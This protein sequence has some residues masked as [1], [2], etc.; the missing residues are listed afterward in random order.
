MQN[1]LIKLL[2]KKKS[3]GQNFLTDKNIANKIIALTVIKNKYVLE[4]G[5]GLG[6]LTDEIIKKEP[7]ELIL[8]EK[9]NEIC[10]FLRDKYKNINEIKIF[11]LDVLDFNY[12]SEVKNNTNVI[13]NLPYNLSTKIILDILKNKKYFNELV[14][15]VQKEVAN[16]MDYNNLQKFNKYKFLIEACGKYKI[17]FNVSNNVFIPKPKVQSSVIKIKLNNKD[18]DFDKLIIF[19]NKIFKSKR[20]K[21]SN[22]ININD[23]IIRD[24]RAEDL[25]FNDLIKL[26]NIF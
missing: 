16:K 11:N 5:P 10:K 1:K 19:S 21:I 9:D 12:E 23:N 24:K 20:K 14:L 17:C 4:I 6:F 22:L 3:L 7:K 8:I 25:E 2:I 15:M 18:F 26:F 13:S